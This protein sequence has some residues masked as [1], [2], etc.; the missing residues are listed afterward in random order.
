MWT[1]PLSEE[2]CLMFVVELFVGCVCVLIVIVATGSHYVP[3]LDLE[4]FIAGYS[5]NCR[6]LPASVNICISDMYI[7]VHNTYIANVQL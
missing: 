1:S 6:D 3:L 5:R 7:R 2:Y 4:F